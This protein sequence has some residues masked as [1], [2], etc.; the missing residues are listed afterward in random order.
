MLDTSRDANTEYV[1]TDDTDV[2]E[3]KKSGRGCLPW[4]ILLLVLLALGGGG[5]YVGATTLFRTEAP[6]PGEA[7]ITDI[8]KRTIMIPGEFGDMR[9]PDRPATISVAIG[10]NLF[11]NGDFAGRDAYSCATCHGSGGIGDSKLGAA[12]YPP[13]NDLSEERTRTKS[14]GQLFW[15]IAHGINLTGMPG[16]SKTYGNPPNFGPYTDDEIWSLVLYVRQIQADNPPR[17]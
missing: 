17:K 16:W 15:L 14:D 13:A 1:V 6:L 10:K 2:V 12:M 4:I 3:E 11:L 7:Q 8:L 5:A 9:V